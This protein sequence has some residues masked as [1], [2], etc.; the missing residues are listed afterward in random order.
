MG[1]Y[2]NTYTAS[3]AVVIG[4]DDYKNDRLP[5]LST[6]AKG[7]RAVAE[8][9]HEELGFD[10]ENIVLL[11]NEQATQRAIRRAMTDPL[12]R[13]EK[14]GPDDRVIIYFGGHG[15]TFDT[16]QGEVGCIAPYDIEPGYI[17]S[18]I[19]MDELTRLA[20]RIHAKHVLFLLDACF[21]GFATMREIPSGVQRQIDDYLTR[22]A[23]QVV[24]AGMRDQLVADTWGPDG[25]ALFTGFLLEGLRGAAPTPGGVLRAFHLAGYLQDE[26]AAH[27][28]SLQTPQYAA[29][30]GSGGGDF[31]F[32]VRDVVALP[33]WLIAAAASDDAAARLVAADR[34]RALAEDDDA[35]IADQALAR[36]TEMSDGD[37]DAL[38]RSLTQEALGELMPE[39]IIA[40]VERE[41]PVIPA[42]VSPENTSAGPDSVPVADEEPLATGAAML[43]S[44]PATTIGEPAPAEPEPEP[45]PDFMED[46]GAVQPVEVGEAVFPVEDVERLPAAPRQRRRPPVWAWIGGAVAGVALLGVMALAGVFGPRAAPTPEAALSAVT[47]TAPP[48]AAGGE[49][50][51]EAPVYQ[52]TIAPTLTPTTPPTSTPTVAPTPTPAVRSLRAFEGHIGPV[53]SAAFSADGLTLASGAE[54][55]TVMVWDVVSGEQLRTLEGHAMAVSGV[56]FSPGGAVMASGSLDQSV[57]LWDVATGERVRTLTDPASPVYGVALSPDGARLASGAEDGTVILWDAATGEQVRTLE[58]HTAAASSVTFSPDGAALASG[59]EDGA[60]I[61][62]NVATGERIHTLEGH[63]AG[64][65]SVAFSP[66]GATLASGADDST[67]ILWDAATGERVRTLESHTAGV[68]S[69]AFSPDGATLAAGTADGAVILWDAAAGDLTRRLVGDTDDVIGVAFLPDG[70][71]LASASADGTIILRN[72][73]GEEPG[74]ESPSEG[75]AVCITS[76]EDVNGNS[77]R[78]PEEG[79]VAGVIIMLSDGSDLLRLYTTDGVSEPYC[80]RDLP[81]GSYMVTWTDNV[82]AGSTENIWAVSVTDGAIVSREFGVQPT[83]Q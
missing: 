27:S 39:T 75:G 61:L 81:A 76:Y 47:Q 50:A 56:A 24:T 57:I 62:W 78:D 31:V 44:A 45:A 28:H 26:V 40:P 60:V 65:S 1:Q 79:K 54:D 5:P 82:F 20:E 53:Y 12:S 71:V 2:T 18:T 80:F 83:G 36:L 48:T 3:H 74:E 32:S 51:T 6:G 38:V 22:P 23:R 43:E 33:E 72:V 8:M 10:A 70:V 66:D 11:Q 7:A 58:G 17:D 30:M 59:A 67:V 49:P 4:I 52:P 15:V 9:L 55:G 16:A 63:T 69:V 46:G 64:V 25:H 41:E 13:L 14:V 73:T 21:S 29:L 35:D 19:P 42:D 37:P 68:S 77:I 34:L